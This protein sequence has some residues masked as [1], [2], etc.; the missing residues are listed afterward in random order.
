MRYQ[1]DPGIAS[2]IYSRSDGLHDMLL[3]SVT[4]ALFVG[5]V[6]LVLGLRGRVLWLS[7][8]SAMLIALSLL[9]IGADLL[10]YLR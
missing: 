8:W 7:T 1:D 4:I 9:Y 5:I 2:R 10:G 3:F 6:L